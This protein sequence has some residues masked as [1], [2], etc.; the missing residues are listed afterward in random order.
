MN[1]TQQYHEFD[2]VDSIWNRNASDEYDEASEERDT[3][4]DL[5]SVHSIK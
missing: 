5:A 4:M 2:H 1:N 3:H